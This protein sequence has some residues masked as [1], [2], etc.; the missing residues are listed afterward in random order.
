MENQIL[1]QLEQ[2]LVGKKSASS[3]RE[4][5]YMPVVSGVVKLLRLLPKENQSARIGRL[6]RVV[7]NALKSYDKDQREEARE[8]LFNIVQ[9]LGPEWLTTVLEEMRATL[10][11]GYQLHVLPTPYICSSAGQ[12]LCLL[13]LFPR[14]GLW[15]RQKTLLQRCKSAKTISLP[16][17]QALTQIVAVLEKDL[18]GDEA[19]QKEASSGYKSKINGPG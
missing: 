5:L 18:F 8:A 7:C 14:S 11:E 4:M 10:V 19:R 13:L 3:E 2:Q 16:F 17:D 9:T 12:N 1:P 15:S 6:L